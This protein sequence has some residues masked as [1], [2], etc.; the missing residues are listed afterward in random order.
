M[1]DIGGS[2]RFARVV[3]T[4]C[5]ERYHLVDLEGERVGLLDLHYATMQGGE[6][7][8]GTLLLLKEL[9]EEEEQEIVEL[10]NAEIID[11]H[12]PEMLRED[13]VLEVFRGK[14]GATYTDSEDFAGDEVDLPF[15]GEEF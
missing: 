8:Y 12:A 6:Y 3:R 9:Q 5:S 1:A 2:L 10:V 15:G 14:N 7:V 4:A 13:F 11:G